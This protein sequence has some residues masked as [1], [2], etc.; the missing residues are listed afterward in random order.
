MT[1]ITDPRLIKLKGLLFLLVGLLSAALL[2]IEH[3]S[4]DSVKRSAVAFASEST[5][6]S[7]YNSPFKKHPVR[8]PGLQHTRVSKEY[9]RPRAL[10]RRIALLF[11]RA[12]KRD[13]DHQ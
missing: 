1:D 5:R 6:Q 11:E 3:P 10:T 13:G 7:T 12:D 2:I 4:I 8:E 9:C